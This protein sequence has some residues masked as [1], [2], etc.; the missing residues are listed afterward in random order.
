MLSGK[1]KQYAISSIHIAED[2]QRRELVGIEELAQSIKTMGL[3]HPI[4]LTPDG[5]LVAGERRLRAH[6]HLGLTH[7]LVQF[8][9]DLPREELEAI[10][11]EE[12]LKRK[13]LGWKEE[14]EAVRRIHFL[15][16]SSNLDWTANDTAELLSV[17]TGT[18][19]KYLLVAEFI[20]KEEP[21]VLAADNFSVAY[22]ICQRKTQRAI[23]EDDN[24][25]DSVFSELF[26]K[27]VSMSN[28][29]TKNPTQE[30]MKLPVAQPEVPYLNTD[31]IEW[32][33]Q[34]WTGPKFNFIHCD[35]PYGIN[36]DKH[37]SGTA[38]LLGGYEDTPE[39]YQACIAGLARMM[40]DRVAE[41]AHLMFWLSARMEIISTTWNQLNE[42]GWK[43]NPVPLIWHRSDNAGVLP[44]PQRGPRQIYETCI[45]GARGDRK[46]V[47]AVSN[48]C[49][50]PKTREVHPSEK[51]RPM[52]QHFFRM[53]VDESTVFL[54]PTM[55]S[56]NSVLAVEDAMSKP[57]FV[58]GLERDK[59][60]FDNALA[61]RKR[62]KLRE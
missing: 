10:E 61:Y 34:P 42:M 51:P 30:V 38:G 32:T 31:Y 43:M 50:H 45:F 37:D 52:L 59:E 23:V 8:T 28:V 21:L 27:P 4:V 5:S 40:E 55:G 26:A 53:F 12:N 48:L 29:G 54:D 13:A 16:Q 46:I 19:S 11:L 56:G 15:K 60:I 35:F 44:D 39:L 62:V 22:N 9:T 1:F 20:E 18:V 57:K 33:K 2:R 25:V 14:V 7:I 17:S 6:Q 24:K 3:I 47:Q 36:Y 49:P 58:L 41:S